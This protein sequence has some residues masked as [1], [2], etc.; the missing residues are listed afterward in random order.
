MD[1][2]IEFGKMLI[3]A[4]VVLYA[5]YLTVKTMLANEVEKKML[6]VQGQNKETV[7]PIRLQAYERICLLLERLS[8]NNLIIRLN[9]QKFSAAEFQHM[10]ILEINNE[11]NHNL[12]QQVYMS[13]EAWELIKNSKEDL[14]A[15]IN[16]AGEGMK[17]E[18]TSIDLA[19]EVF[20]RYMETNPDPIQ[21]ALQFVKS[22][23]QKEF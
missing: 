10:L 15:A 20:Q 7:L 6:D 9:T 22:E 8:P 13:H 14:I 2:V 16:K 23:I 19:K 3:P 11:F 18:S 4:G 12:S 1:A 21:H 5:V 17:E